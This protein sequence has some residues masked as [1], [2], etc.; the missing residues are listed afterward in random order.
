MSHGPGAPERLFSIGHS[1]HDLERFLELLRAR[2]VEVLEDVRS[3][4]YA[5][6]ATHFSQE[7][8]RPAVT[9]AGVKY[10]FLG[11]E[12]GGRPEGDEFYDAEAHVRYDRLAVAPLFLEGI[13]RIVRGGRQYAVAL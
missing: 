12:L 11:R 6:Y 4:P 2:G 8:L 9:A 3:Q 1:N 13:E 7:T 5:R 10:L